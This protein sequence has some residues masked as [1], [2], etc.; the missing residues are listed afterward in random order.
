MK[1]K[2]L[3]LA[4]LSPRQMEYNKEISAAVSSAYKQLN[5]KDSRDILVIFEDSLLATVIEEA[6]STV[7]ELG[8]QLYD[9]DRWRRNIAAVNLKY[10]EDFKRGTVGGTGGG[11]GLIGF[12]IADAIL[13]I[14]LWTGRHIFGDIDTAVWGKL[15]ESFS[16]IFKAAQ[17]IDKT[18]TI[19]ITANFN[20][21]IIFVFPL[22][23]TADVFLKE[24][25]SLAKTTKELLQKDPRPNMAY[26]YT[27]HGESGAWE[28]E[29]KIADYF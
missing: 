2:N 23:M 8:I 25:N 29:S 17:A 9:E 5:N 24:M 18:K 27:F 22:S 1:Q 16:S 15:K 10:Q 4:G 28:F 7:N 26:K 21:Q 6:L 12:F 11:G 14:T 20:P 13:R 19:T 3:V